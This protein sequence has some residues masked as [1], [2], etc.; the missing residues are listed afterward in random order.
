M[1][2]NV[3]SNVNIKSKKTKIQRFVKESKNYFFFVFLF[4]VDK[5]RKNKHLFI[6]LFL[7][8]LFYQIFQRKIFK[9]SPLKSDI[10]SKLK[11][12]QLL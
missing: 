2:D 6:F 9:N 11:S 7:F 5:I 10:Q 1:I 3:I 8:P 4:C 12:K